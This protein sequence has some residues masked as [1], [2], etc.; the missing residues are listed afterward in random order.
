MWPSQASRSRATLSCNSSYFSYWQGTIQASYAVMR[1]LL[2][3]LFCRLLIFFKI[4]FLKKNSLR[5]TIKM[6][7]SLDLDQA[8][9]LSGLIWIQTVCK[10]YQQT[11]LVDKDLCLLLSRCAAWLKTPKIILF[12][13]K[14][15]MRH[16]I[17]KSTWWHLCA[18]GSW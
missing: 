1:Q 8:Q 5:N 6:S 2:F 14:V 18:E 7:N 12:S 10:G 13:D 3:I 17:E 4:N 15:N 9:R 16:T 11:T